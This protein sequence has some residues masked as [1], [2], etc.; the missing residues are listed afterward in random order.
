MNK[1]KQDTSRA[2]MYSDKFTYTLTAQRG[3]LFV[4]FTSYWWGN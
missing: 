1:K 4:L 3:S 2:A